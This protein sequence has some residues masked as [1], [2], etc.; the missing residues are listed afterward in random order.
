[1][2][3]RVT[4]AAGEPEEAENKNI[5]RLLRDAAA[6]NERLQAALVEAL[7]KVEAYRDL[8]DS[9][10]TCTLGRAAKIIGWPGGQGEFYEYLIRK[11]DIYSKVNY[12][13]YPY[14]REYFPTESSRSR[15]Y[16]IVN[17]S[18]VRCGDKNVVAHTTKVTATGLD[19]LRRL[20]KKDFDL[21]DDE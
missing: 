19:H 15:S 9:D 17:V 3:E 1:M 6:V 11:N 4:T 18:T 10:G 14:K 21:E 20:I 7:P 8:M 12:D 2:A 16:F 5:N 13:L